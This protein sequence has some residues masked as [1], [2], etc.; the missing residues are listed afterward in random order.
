M[1]NLRKQPYNSL[2]ILATCHPNR[3][4]AT[5]AH[6]LWLAAPLGTLPHP[7]AFP[8]SIISRGN[9]RGAAGRVGGGGS[10]TRSSR[11]H[12]LGGGELQGGEECRRRAAC[13]E[14]IPIT[15]R[16]GQP[17]HRATRAVMERPPG[18]VRQRGA[19][20]ADGPACRPTGFWQPT[21][22]DSETRERRDVE[23]EGVVE[24]RWR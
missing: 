11:S 3:Q 20:V 14:P 23:I 19:V 2:F 8:P 12:A 24:G 16:S 9:F 22:P 6:Y 15:H 7:R 17:R 5:L 21:A 13:C 18:R 1:K 4:N 10:S